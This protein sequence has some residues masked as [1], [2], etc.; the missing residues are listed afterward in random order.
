MSITVNMPRF[1][2]DRL[3]R[4]LFISINELRDFFFFFFQ[5]VLT[6]VSFVKRDRPSTRQMERSTLIDGSVY[7]FIGSIGRA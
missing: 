2:L 4:Y 1:G 3:L 7:L 5:I 6:N